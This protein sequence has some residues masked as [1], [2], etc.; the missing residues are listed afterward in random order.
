MKSFVRYTKLECL[1]PWL[2]RVWLRTV[3]SLGTFRVSGHR[4]ARQIR[5]AQDFHPSADESNT[6]R[7]RM[8]YDRFDSVIG[9]VKK[10]DRGTRRITDEE[11]RYREMRL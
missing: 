6:S 8:L 10:A 11:I 4:L 7:F 3:D 1:I 2:V 9:K 5:L